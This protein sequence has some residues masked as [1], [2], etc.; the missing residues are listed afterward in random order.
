MLLSLLVCHAT[1]IQWPV[2][3]GTNYLMCSALRRTILRY[4]NFNTVSWRKCVAKCGTDEPEWRWKVGM[5]N[6]WEVS[7]KNNNSD[8]HSYDIDLRD[9]LRI[10]DVAEGDNGALYRCTVTYFIDQNRSILAQDSDLIHLLFKQ[11]EGNSYT[12]NNIKEKRQKI[13]L[14]FFVRL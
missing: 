13:N 2:T 6:Q 8:S 5:N 4:N 1:P 7:L 9:F 3:H 12:Y 11:E 10:S 14:L